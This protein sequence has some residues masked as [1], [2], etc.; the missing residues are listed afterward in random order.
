MG[1]T[2]QSCK[3]MSP[4]REAS[5]LSL[6]LKRLEQLHQFIE[7]R[8]KLVC[9]YYVI[10]HKMVTRNKTHI[11]K[12]GSDQMNIKYCQNTA[13]LLSLN[14]RE[15]HSVQSVLP[16]RKR[17]TLSMSWPHPTP[18]PGPPPCAVYVPGLAAR[19]GNPHKAQGCGKLKCGGACKGKSCS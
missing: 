13:I 16:C 4:F 9:T 6:G 15:R 17:A 8:A 2:T 18:G 3:S 7:A 5:D 11:L 12:H 10:P 1:P 19:W 14:L